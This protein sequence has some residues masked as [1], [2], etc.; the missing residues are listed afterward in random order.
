M[1]KSEVTILDTFK[2]YILHK[3]NELE[4]KYENE[5]SV[6]WDR[7]LGRS[8]CIEQIKIILSECGTSE[9]I[10]NNSK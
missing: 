9:L 2:I 6:V 7:R 8:E 3:I 1:N 10:S 5:N 4:I